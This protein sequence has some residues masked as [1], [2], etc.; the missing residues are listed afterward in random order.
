MNE[1]PLMC[2]C[3]FES[4]PV[5]RHHHPI[6]GMR[7]GYRVARC[8]RVVAP[9]VPREW[10]CHVDK[11]IIHS[12]AEIQGLLGWSHDASRPMTS[13]GSER[14]SLRTQ[15]LLCGPKPTMQQRVGGSSKGRCDRDGRVPSWW[16]SLWAQECWLR[17]LKP[18]LTRG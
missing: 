4:V 16:G 5:L 17:N 11:S 14:E 12:A 10:R 8:D 15:P 6:I 1:M 2:I 18:G 13:L 3:V 9:G 7:R